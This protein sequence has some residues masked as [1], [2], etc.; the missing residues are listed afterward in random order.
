M[1]CE[2]KK[3]F[4]FVWSL[5]ELLSTR[6]FE[7]NQLFIPCQFLLTKSI[8]SITFKLIILQENYFVSFI[9]K[10]Y[11]NYAIVKMIVLLVLFFKSLENST[12]LTSVDHVI[13]VNIN[14]MMLKGPST[15]RKTAHFYRDHSSNKDLVYF[16]ISS[17][18]HNFCCR[19]KC[20]SFV[21]MSN[22]TCKKDFCLFANILKT[23]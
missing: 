23:V 15:N 3:P 13:Y 11:P 19:K 4:W 14:Q 21:F 2:R 7:F 5:S 17:M 10:F 18:L 16:P 20:V 9:I 6:A 22:T 12:Y 1:S 8:S